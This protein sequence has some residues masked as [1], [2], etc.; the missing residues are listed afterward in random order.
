MAAFDGRYVWFDL[1]TTDVPRA[2]DFYSDVV[3]WK[4]TRWPGGDYEMWSAGDA[5]VGGLEEEAPEERQA[6]LPPRW[7]A[8]IGASDV[9]ATA[10]S[11]QEL[12]GKVLVPPKDIPDVGRFAVLADPQGAE[13][14]VFK[15]SGA[16]E[17][18]DTE[19]LGRFGWLELNTTDWQSAWKFYSA[20]FGWQET[21][22]IDMGPE[23]GK[24][25]MFGTDSNEAIGGMSNAAAFMKAPAH[26]LPYVNVKN[27]DEAAREIE[28]IGG[29]ALN[30]P[31]D[32]PGGRI[33]QCIDPQGAMFA[34][35]SSATH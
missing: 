30:G 15:P 4:T 13:F 20:L 31:M 2:K 21:S 12:G 35:F 33:A 28:K 10:K 19:A 32:V 26:W 29:K 16:G 5:Q 9:D 23:F 14:A 7:L 1:R 6:G 17:A 8:Y 3:G 25:L 18:P 22:S 11:A 24:Y 27:T 34:I